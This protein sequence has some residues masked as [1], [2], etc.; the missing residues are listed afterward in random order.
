MLCDRVLR[1]LGDDTPA[2]GIAIPLTW[3]E[4]RS[5]ALAKPL[6]DGDTLRILL[7]PGVVLQ[8]G[9]VLHEADGKLI[10]ITLRPAEV[11]RAEIANQAELLRVVYALG[12]LHFPLQIDGHMILTPADGPARAVFREL[13]I[14]ATTVQRRFQPLPLPNG[15]SFRL[16]GEFSVVRV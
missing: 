4:C 1:N 13:G 10:Y 9:D 12:N 7:S 2:G 14:T 8:H 11:L 3:Q 6:P 5:R 15:V 16:S